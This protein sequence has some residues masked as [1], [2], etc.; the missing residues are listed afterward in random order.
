ML[1]AEQ[2]KFLEKRGY[3]STGIEDVGTSL[4]DVLRKNK[5]QCLSNA[6]R[7]SEGIPEASIQTICLIEIRPGESGTIGFQYNKHTGKIE[8]FFRIFG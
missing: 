4:I 8:E 5:A 1:L 3:K 2:V 6:V 7:S